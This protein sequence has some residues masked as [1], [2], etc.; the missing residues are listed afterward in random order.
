MVY[1]S[2]GQNDAAFEWLDKAFEA[3]DMWINFLRVDP[4]M[5]SLRRSPRYIELLR[6]VALPD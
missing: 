6:R 4:K 3:H 5:D 2:L 1:A